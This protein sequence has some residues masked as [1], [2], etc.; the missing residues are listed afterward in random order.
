METEQDQIELEETLEETERRQFDRERKRKSMFLM[1]EV[2]AGR[3]R[4]KIADKR[5]EEC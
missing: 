4:M 2:V 5:V 1:I 3:R